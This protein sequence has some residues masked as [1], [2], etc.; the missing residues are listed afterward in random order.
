ML[1]VRFLQAYLVTMRPY[2]MVLSGTTGIAGLSLAPEVGL[3]RAG[4]IALASFLSYGFG[5]ALTD[6]FQIDTDGI[7]ASYRPLTQGVISRGQVLGVSLAG[8]VLCVMAFA[9]SNAW[10]LL[11]GAIAAGG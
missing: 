8:L 3:P 9:V 2:L 1:S 4:T 6:C 5:Q 7:S 11:L 10:N